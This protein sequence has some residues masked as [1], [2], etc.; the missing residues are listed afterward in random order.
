[1]A[2]SRPVKRLPW[3]LFAARKRIH[4]ASPLVRAGFGVDTPDLQLVPEETTSDLA[5]MGVSVCQTFEI[6][7]T[8]V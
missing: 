4:R 1:M 3:K 7:L 5:Q 8:M 6:T 2:N